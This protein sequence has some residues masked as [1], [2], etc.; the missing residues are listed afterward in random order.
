M[1]KYYERDTANTCILHLGSQEMMRICTDNDEPHLMKEMTVAVNKAEAEEQDELEAT[2]ESVTPKGELRND[3]NKVILK[4]VKMMLDDIGLTT[5][6]DL[7]TIPY[8]I[9][10]GRGN[11]PVL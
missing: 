3:A 10:K 7:S 6:P 4:L 9:S 8:V 1:I 11:I 2:F 5:G